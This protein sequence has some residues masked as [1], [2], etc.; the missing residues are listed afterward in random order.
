MDPALL[1]FPVPGASIIWGDVWKSQDSSAGFGYNC[2]AIKTSIQLSSN[3]NSSN[4]YD[5]FWN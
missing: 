4:Y 5:I 3:D 2:S 1:P